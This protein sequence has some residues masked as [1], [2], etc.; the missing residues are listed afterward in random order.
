MS[1]VS[2]N[3]HSLYGIRNSYLIINFT[4][5]IQMA[6]RYTQEYFFQHTLMNVSFTYLSEIIHRNTE[7]IPQ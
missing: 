6:S 5:R 2:D 1:S 7:S 4:F 3:L